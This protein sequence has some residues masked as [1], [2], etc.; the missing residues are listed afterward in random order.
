MARLEQRHAARASSDDYLFEA[1]MA[2]YCLCDASN[3]FVPALLQSDQ[4]FLFGELVDTLTRLKRHG[5]IHNVS[6][7]VNDTNLALLF[8]CFEANELVSRLMSLLELVELKSEADRRAFFAAQL[9][10]Q[11]ELR[12]LLRLCANGNEK[13]AHKVAE[14]VLDELLRCGAR[15]VAEHAS[16]A[17]EVAECAQLVDTYCFG[18][19]QRRLALHGWRVA[20]RWIS[21]AQRRAWRLLCGGR[22]ARAVLLCARGVGVSGVAGGRGGAAV[23]RAG[24]AAGASR[25]RRVV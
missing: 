20:V 12:A 10:K 9:S 18:D 1:Q 8:A 22:G 6:A 19:G 3:R 7:F 17:L 25:E 23:G 21:A 14:D 4:F 13:L 2:T 15:I 5:V 11:K 16:V 24:R